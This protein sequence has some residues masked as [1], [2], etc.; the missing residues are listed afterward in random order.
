MAKSSFF[1]AAVLLSLLPGMARAETANEA[2][3]VVDDG[4]PEITIAV[5]DFKDT[6]RAA[7]EGTPSIE[8]GAP[9]IQGVM[10]GSLDAQST[11]PRL[12]VAGLRKSDKYFCVTVRSADGYYSGESVPV[13]VPKK[14]RG[15]SVVRVNLSKTNARIAALPTREVAALVRTSVNRDCDGRGMILAA[16]WQPPKT[17]SSQKATVLLGGEGRTKTPDIRFASDDAANVCVQLKSARSLRGFR[18]ACALQSDNCASQAKVAIAW[19]EGREREPG[20]RFS[21]R[22]ACMS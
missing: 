19:Q 9:R 4:T 17:W 2:P 7:G 3:M 21:F 8:V 22:R 6:D 10:L 18:W 11:Y 15:R 5:D 12:Y 13:S 14:L 20:P 16:S 1:S